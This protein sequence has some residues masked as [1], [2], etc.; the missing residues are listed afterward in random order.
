MPSR[1]L[2]T[3]SVLAAGVLAPAARRRRRRGKATYPTVKKIAPMTVS[4]GETMTVT[5]NGF[6][7]G[8]G[9]NTVVF[10]RAGKRAIFVKA[11]GLSSTRLSVV[12]PEKLRTCSPRRR[13]GRR[14]PLPDPHP[15]QALRQDLH[16]ADKSPT[17]RA[18]AVEGR[19]GRPPRRPPP[20][21]GHRR[22][23]RPPDRPPRRRR[24]T[25]T[26]TARSTRRHRRRQRPARRRHRGDASAPTAAWPTPTAT[27]CEDGWEYKSA[28]DLNQRVRA[29]AARAYP[30]PC[31]A[32]CRPYPGKRAYPNPLDGT[33]AGTDYDGDWLT[34]AQEHQAW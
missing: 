27:A 8:K 6:V 3:L 31:A 23:R 25:A 21:A 9:K 17:V 34:R 11:D 5:G 2:A 24:R 1:T 33:D 30:T 16:A 13:R 10:R 7:K 15:R 4:V 26:A 32:G 22:R 14:D 18:G 19:R 29:P 20:A 28:F 12:V